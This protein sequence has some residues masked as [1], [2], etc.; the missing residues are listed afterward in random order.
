MVMTGETPGQYAV[1]GSTN[2]I[3]KDYL[4]FGGNMGFLDGH[5]EWRNF[6]NPRSG[7]EGIMYKRFGG[8]GNGFWW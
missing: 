4:P 3:K 6:G 8:D 5:A 1:P 7:D 2:N